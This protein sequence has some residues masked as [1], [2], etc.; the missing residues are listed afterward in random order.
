MSPVQMSQVQDVLET[1]ALKKNVSV[2]VPQTKQAQHGELAKAIRKKPSKQERQAS[3]KKG[4]KEREYTEEEFQ[5]MV[6]AERRAARAVLAR[7]AHLA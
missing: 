5:T 6:A 4:T 7:R 2:I 3:S 1:A